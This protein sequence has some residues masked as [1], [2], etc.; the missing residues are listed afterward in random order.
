MRSPEPFEFFIQILNELEIKYCVTGSIASIIFGEPRLTHDID[1][2]IHMDTADIV[3]L[4]SSFLPS[5]FYLPPDDII[6]IELRRHL[7]GHFNIIHQKSGFKADIY[8]CGR[9]DFMLWA[10][11]NSISFDLGGTDIKLAP[12]EYVIV[13]KLEYF[14]EGGSSKHLTDI[15]SILENQGRNINTELLDTLLSERNLRQEFDKAISHT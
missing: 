15:R 1:I 11:A 12:P 6:E 10:I 9:D 13:K 5:D 2:I 14:R 4:Q 8:P 7:R 3:K